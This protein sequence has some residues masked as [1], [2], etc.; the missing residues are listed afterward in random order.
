M[1]D[2]N[3]SSSLPSDTDSEDSLESLDTAYA[4]VLNLT[5]T[6]LRE[7]GDISISELGNNQ[8]HVIDKVILQPSEK[9]QVTAGPVIN[10]LDEK[11]GVSGGFHSV[12]NYILHL[13]FCTTTRSKMVAAGGLS[14]IVLV[15]LVVVLA[16]ILPPDASSS[17][18]TSASCTK[19]HENVSS[20][21]PS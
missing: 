9:V 16:V 4:R 18:S 3:P 6:G 14:L 13:H 15:T 11:D 10:I 8:E 20:L 19:N 1:G 21:R 2:S 7:N 12:S 17:S 5:P